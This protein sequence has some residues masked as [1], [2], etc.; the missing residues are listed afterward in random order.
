MI[1]FTL[2]VS[3]NYTLLKMEYIKVPVLAPHY[4]IST[5]KM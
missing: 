4:L 5:W 1:V 3:N 2:K